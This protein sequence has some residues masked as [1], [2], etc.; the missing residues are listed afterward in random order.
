MK[1]GYIV[2]ESGMDFEQ[3][4]CLEKHES[5]P[6]EGVLGWQDEGFNRHVFASRKLAREAI[7][8]TYH[9]AKAFGYKNMPE[10]QF[11]KIHPVDLP[12]I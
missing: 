4:L 8:R 10:K 3:V 7:N 5:Y 11:C 6:E 2:V 9:Y 12:E 1:K